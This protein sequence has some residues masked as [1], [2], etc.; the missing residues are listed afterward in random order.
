M[1]YRYLNPGPRALRSNSSATLHPTSTRNTLPVSPLQHAVLLGPLRA[2]TYVCIHGL[3]AATL[4]SLWA[5]RVPFWGSV[6]AGAAV[7]M[8]GQFLYLV[9]SSATMNENLFALMLSNVYN[10]LVR[11][12]WGAR[13]RVG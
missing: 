2:A 1:Y 6:A 5:A 3:L 7:R 8:A 11:V 12:G 13:E 9:L 10:M 4:G